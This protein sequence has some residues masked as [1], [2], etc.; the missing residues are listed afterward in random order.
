[1]AQLRI[2]AAAPGYEPFQQA[3]APSDELPDIRLRP[4][5]EALE[6]AAWERATAANTPEAFSEYLAAFP[7]GIHAAEARQRLDAFA[8]ARE[9]AA[10]QAAQQAN[11]IAAYQA[12]LRDYPNG[13]YAA[14]AR[15]RLAQLQDEAAWQQARAAGTPEACRK[16]LEEWP[17]GG[18]VEEARKCAEPEPEMPAPIR[19]LT[20]DMVRV[21]G[22]PFTMGCQEGRDTD[23]DDDEKPRHDVTVPD[24]SI[25]RYE[26]TQEQWRAVMGSDPPELY[27]KGCDQCPVERVSW[28][29]IKEFL[30]KLNAMTGQRFRL[31]TEAEWEYAARGGR[32]SQGFLYSGSNN[33]DEVAWY[34]ENYR[35]GNTHGEQQTTRPVGGKKANELGLYD[36]SGNVWEWVEDD[37]HNNYEGAPTNGSAWVDRPDRGAYRVYRGGGWVNTAGFCRAARRDLDAP[38]G[39]SID[40]G[41]RLAL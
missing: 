17:Q 33:I 15:Q 12:F 3:R 41:F 18:H 5:A 26:V 32:R 9:L 38:A 13:A 28:N 34:G 31:P 4:T 19:K 37:W 35:Q 10:W 20:G 8:S 27:N 22:G 40:V 14:T 29:D 11:A 25:G 16:Y 23:C 30:Q 36:M 1:M 24:F 7:A 39:R 6:A 21:Q 2:Y